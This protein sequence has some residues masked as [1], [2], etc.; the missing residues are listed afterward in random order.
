MK[1]IK[2]TQGKVALVDDDVYELLKGYSWHLQNGGYAKRDTS[3]KN[4]R[5]VILMHREIMNP[6][7]GM[8]VDHIDGNKLNNQKVNLRLV[9][10]CHNMQNKGKTTRN[11]SGYKGVHWNG[12]KWIASIGVNATTKYIGSYDTKEGAARAWNEAAKLYH[13]EFAKLNPVD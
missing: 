8:E 1:E 4:G 11:K 7:P 2:L 9:V 10:R 3:R 6:P 12:R 13:G 5:K